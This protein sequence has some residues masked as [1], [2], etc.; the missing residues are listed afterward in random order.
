V[1]TMNKVTF[2]RVKQQ[3][4]PNLYVATKDGVK[5]G[6][7]YKPTDTVSDK[8]AWRCYVGIGDSAKFLYHTWKKNVA[9]MGVMLAVN[10]TIK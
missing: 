5:V 6:F 1:S 3:S 8:N 9:M 10:N 7:I 4:L 2:K